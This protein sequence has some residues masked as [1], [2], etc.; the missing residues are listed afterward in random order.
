MHISMVGPDKMRVTWIT[1]DDASA[2]VEYGTTPG[3]Y[4]FSATGSTTSYKYIY[5]SV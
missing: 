2:T 5:R 4:P 3:Q 1:D